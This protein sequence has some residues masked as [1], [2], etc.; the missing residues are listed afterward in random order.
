MS[1]SA[2]SPAS[3]TASASGAGVRAGAASASASTPSGIPSTSDTAAAA[4]GHPV[5]IVSISGPPSYKFSLDEEAVRSILGQCDP[6]RKV[7][8]VSVVGAFRTGKSFLLSWFTRYLERTGGSPEQDSNASSDEDA[9]VLVEESD[10]RPPTSE[11]WYRKSDKLISSFRWRG[12]AE[13]ETTGIWMYSQPF[14]VQLTS[15]ETISV[16]LVDTQGMF[17]HE[18]TMDL[19]AA[20]F[21]L[22]TLLSSH[23]VYNVEKRVQEDHLQQLA[24]FS[25]YGRLA[26]SVEKDDQEE[27]D[28]AHTDED[29][30]VITGSELPPPS[31]SKP[32]QRIEFLVRDW[33]NFDE[34]DL[35]DL[36]IDNLVNGMDEYLQ[37]VISDRDGDSTSDLADTRRQISSCF[38]QTKC[39]LLP[40]PGLAVT[41]KKY[42]G[43]VKDIDPNFLILLDTYCKRVFDP[44][45]L[46]PKIVHGRALDPA[47]LANYIICYAKLF[48]DGACFPSAKTV[49][50]ATCEANVASATSTALSKYRQEMDRVAGPTASHFVPADEFATHHVACREGALRLYNATANFG[51]AE[52]IS[53]GLKKVEGGIDESCEMY[54]GLNKAR[55]PLHGL[56]AVLLP[57]TVAAVSYVMRIV[58]DVT[59]SGWSQTCKASSAVLSEVYTVVFIFLLIVASTKAQALKQQYRRIAEVVKVVIGGNTGSSEGGSSSGKTKEE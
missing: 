9:P 54:D 57:L 40:H 16:L 36:N 24:L 31:P 8:V 55:D 21:G 3:D 28:N 35:D 52:T 53:T 42:D 58:A 26:M 41:K 32:F 51:P 49:L 17:D 13:R 7:S 6:S 50:A 22:S 59:C 19:T 46:E 14:S 12:G 43:V 47:S 38:D 4:G 45:T 39:F 1:G 2:P 15:G 10:T 44:S 56:G 20:I 48:Q 11:P 33:Q 34:D 37:S 25:E 29:S 5:Q 23:Q 27:D 30:E 18:T